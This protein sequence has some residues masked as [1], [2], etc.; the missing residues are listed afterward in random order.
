MKY[1]HDA[2]KLLQAFYKLI[3]QPV[4]DK[5]AEPVVALLETFAKLKRGKKHQELW[6]YVADK[7]AD[8]TSAWLGKYEEREEEVAMECQAAG[9]ISMAGL[10][11]DGEHSDEDFQEDDFH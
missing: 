9:A 10:F 5:A 2:D 4:T 8:A 1:K 11:A 6:T 7:A 3:D